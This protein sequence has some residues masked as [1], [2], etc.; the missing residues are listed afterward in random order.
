MMQKLFTIVVLLLFSIA[1]KAQDS[2]AYWPKQIQLQ[3]DYVLTIYA[4]EPENF[5]NNILDARAAFSMHDNNNLPVFGA[6]WF[7]CRV[8]TDVKNNEVNFEDIRLVNASFPDATAETIQ[9]LQ[10]MIAE[11]APNWHFNSILK[12][13]YKNLNVIGINNAYSENLKSNPP[14][15]IY[16]KSPTALVSI[17]GDPIL[18]NINGSEM[19]Q[20]IVNTPQ[21]LIRSSSDKQY[22]LYGG[23]WWYTASDPLGTWKSIETPPAY[24]SQLAKGAKELGSSDNNQNG[25][26]DTAPKLI[27]TK[28]PAEL[29]QT[30]G[31]PEIALVYE[32]LLHVTNSNDEIL[33]DANSDYYY[34]LIAGRWYKTKNMERGTWAFVAPEELPDF[35]KEIPPTSSVSHIRMSIP[36]T[37]E[38][39]SAAL[40]NTI[41]Q[42][43]IV[44]RTK[45][46]MQLEFDGD[47]QF[48]AIEGTSLKYGVN[49]NGSVLQDSTSTYYAVDQAVWFVS[50]NPSGPWKVADVFPKEVKNIP[51]SCPVFNLKFVSV[52]DATSD[53]VYLGY[54]AGYTGAFLYHGVVY[55][56]TGYKYKPWYGSRY[57]PR[58]TTYGN[59]AK[60]KPVNVTVSVSAGYG[61]GYPGMGYGYGMGYPGMG[62]GFGGYPGMYPYGGYEGGVYNSIDPNEAS[63][64]TLSYR[65][66]TV[67]FNNDNNKREKPIDP[68][69]IYNN[70]KIG[71][72]KTEDAQRDDPMKPIILEYNNESAPFH[73]YAD[74]NGN[75]YRQDQ[76]GT[77]YERKDAD[78]QKTKVE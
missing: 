4:P 77:T 67:T 43:A 78:W 57:I 36:G 58:P 33:F 62:Y 34:V 60:K 64:S 24:I 21:F 16:S 37:P 55:Y 2:V 39:I 31:E 26:P 66:E 45:A 63:Y 42:T 13:F 14:K 18:A 19:Y 32:S 65:S 25:D 7:E 9:G 35:F 40:D 23:N 70:R 27:I 28:D 68:K 38:S 41:P 12:S 11:S 30:N 20:Y 5:T 75:L 61:M 17:D 72:I 10:K 52:Y 76:D 51:P 59:G 56:G 74:Q 44:D 69:N 48:E 50:D 22:Y 8:Q 73:M 29:I 47:P 54:T 3:D 71:I 53:I 15:I 6:M 46:T 1:S 49:T